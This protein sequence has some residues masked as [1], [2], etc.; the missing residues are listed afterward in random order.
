[1]N[2]IAV[3]ATAVVSFLAALVVLVLVTLAV[4]GQAEVAALVSAA[5]ALV[6]A[7]AAPRRAR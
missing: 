5:G 4:C 7:V 2:P 3:A 1:V 6:S